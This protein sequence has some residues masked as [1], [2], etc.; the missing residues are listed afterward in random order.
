MKPVRREG[1]LRARE[2]AIRLFFVAYSR[3]KRLLVLTGTD[4]AKWDLVLGRDE[5]GSHI[6]SVEALRELGVLCL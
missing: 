6:N 4:I 1:E 2:D 5:A 3:A